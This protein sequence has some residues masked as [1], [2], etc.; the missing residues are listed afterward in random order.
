MNVSIRR[1]TARDYA[2]V[3]EANEEAFGTPL[4]AGLVDALRA[5]AGAI[6]LVAAIEDRVIGH[7]LFTQ[8]TIESPVHVSVAGLAPMSV[9][10]GY[11]HQGVGGQLVR[12]GLMECRQQGYVAVVVVGHPG[13]YPRFGFVS[14]Q[15]KGLTC[16][17]PVPPEVFMV[18][19][20]R[21]GSLDGLSGV[22]R[23][24]PEFTME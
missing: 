11:Q 7:I 6:S 5:S 22:V 10:P 21:A 23:Y 3:R 8:V 17:F 20:L 14:A 12:A 24:R 13:Y 4:E 19:E 1:E 2:G 18:A 16:E 15:A 9:R